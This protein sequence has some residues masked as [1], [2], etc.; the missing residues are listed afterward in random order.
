[1]PHL[2]FVLFL[3]FRG[4]PL[5]REPVVIPKLALRFN[6]CK[7]W[8]VYCRVF[9]S[10]NSF[11]S[12]I[13]L[14]LYFLFFYNF[15]S[16]NILSNFRSFNFSP[17]GEK[18]HAE[19][20]WFTYSF[21]LSESEPIHCQSMFV[22]MYMHTSRCAPKIYVSWRCERTRNERTRSSKMIGQNKQ[23]RVVIIINGADKV[24]GLTLHYYIIFY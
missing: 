5:I 15:L 8:K 14:I 17:A 13:L 6:D 2:F 21:C 3:A 24:S 4:F 11:S 18:T 10:F 19:Q 12:Y 1:M 9:F 22:Q 20:T 23:Y 16:F 7:R